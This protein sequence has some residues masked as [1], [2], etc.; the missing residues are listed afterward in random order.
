MLSRIGEAIGFAE[1]GTSEGGALANEAGGSIGISNDG[2]SSGGCL[3]IGGGM[4]PG[5][6][7]GGG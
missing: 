2:Q 3:R 6:A 7:P 5:E 1:G 4:A